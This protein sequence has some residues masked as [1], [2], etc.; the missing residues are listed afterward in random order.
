MAQPPPGL[1]VARAR[2]LAQVMAQQPSGLAVLMTA[3]LSSMTEL[4]VRSF[5]VRLTVP[6]RLIAASR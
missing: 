5:P 6:E 3:S 4:R 2:A 1:A